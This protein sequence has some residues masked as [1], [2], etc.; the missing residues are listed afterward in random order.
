MKN[1]LLII[2]VL[3]FITGCS[4]QLEQVYDG[5]KNVQ[6]VIADRNF[7]VPK[8]Y[9]DSP[10]QPVESPLVFDRSGS[11]IAYFNWPSLAG[12][13]ESD[14]QLRFGRFNH[15]IIQIQWYLLDQ[16]PI[17]VIA[18]NIVKNMSDHK[19]FRLNGGF[20]CNW[21]GT[22]KCQYADM[23]GIY[24][25][26]G[27]VHQMGAFAITCPTESS[28]MEK[29]QIC[30]YYLDYSAKNLY[31]ESLISSNM[32]IAGDFP[33]VAQQIKIFLDTWEVQKIDSS[34]RI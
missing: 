27:E 21:S 10:S 2:M 11:M 12:L 30:H 4:P 26:L 15:D 31:I 20:D 33:K 16:Q 9:I 18:Q 13:S 8:K 25:F 28:V 5:E 6:V 24:T 14:N 17:T 1:F 23:T 22:K 29:N 19:A 32:I 3:S 34:K 7:A